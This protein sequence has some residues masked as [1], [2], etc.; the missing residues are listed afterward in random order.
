MTSSAPLSGGTFYGENTHG[1]QQ[2]YPRKPARFKGNRFN[3]IPK[4]MEKSS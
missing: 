2:K 4:M 3:E 1:P